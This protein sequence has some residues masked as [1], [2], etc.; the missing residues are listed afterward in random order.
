[1]GPLTD[2]LQTR[3][4]WR[5]MLRIMGSLIGV[6]SIPICLMVLKPPSKPEKDH[7]RETDKTRCASSDMTRYS[8][9]TS[10][11]Q[12]VLA[13]NRTMITKTNE[14]DSSRLHFPGEGNEVI[15]NGDVS[16]KNL[17]IV[18]CQETDNKL[19]EDHKIET[20]R[21]PICRILGTLTYPD[22]VL[23][24]FSVFGFGFVNSFVIIQLVRLLMFMFIYRNRGYAYN[25]LKLQ[26]QILLY[27]Y[28]KFVVLGVYTTRNRIVLPGKGFPT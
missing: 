2:F 4:G 10:S 9:I 7:Q 11:L 8:E 6:V 16:D 1:M 28:R 21:S 5:N 13:E 20:N 24:S 17:G 14:N 25:W 15:N 19:N 27:P 12:D 26:A 3:F 18:E 23:F 22:V